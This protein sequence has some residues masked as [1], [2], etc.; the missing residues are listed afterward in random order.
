MRAH[1]RLARRRS[2]TWV[3]H[4]VGQHLQHLHARDNC[5]ESSRRDLERPL[6]LGQTPRRMRMK[7]QTNNV[8]SRSFSRMRERI[9]GV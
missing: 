4:L 5:A 9:E 8:R 1:V 6:E 3:R 7:G 2:Q